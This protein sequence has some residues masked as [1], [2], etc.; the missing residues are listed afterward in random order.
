MHIPKASGATLRSIIQN[1][2]KKSVNWVGKG[3]GLSSLKKKVENSD[4]F[5]GHV[6]YGIHKKYSKPSFYITMLRDP[7]DR[8][9]SHYLFM[10]RSSGHIYHEKVKDL[11]IEQFLNSKFFDVQT[12]NLQTRYF[13]GGKTPHLTQ[14]I[15]VMEH[16]IYFVGITERFDDSLKILEHDLG[17]NNL[18]Y[19]K[20]NE[21]PN[22][23]SRSDFSKEVIDQITENNQLDIQLYELA[24]KIFEKKLQAIRTDS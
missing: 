4:A 23:T 3:K 15:K 17:W 6:Y 16:N 13:C 1:N 8:V 12:K 9:I 18:N 19:Q 21:N 24:K 7:V 2:Y 20:I 11:T 14:A 22:K 5:M 10:K